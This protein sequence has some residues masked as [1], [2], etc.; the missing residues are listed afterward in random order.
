MRRA[1]RLARLGAGRVH[2]NP[3]VGAVLVKNGRIVGEGAH[4]EFGGPHAEV[5]AARRAG[6]KTEGATLY[7]TLEPC[8]HFGKTPPCADLL[9]SLKIKKVVVGAIDPNPRVS[10][11]GLRRLRA[12]G[13]EVASGVLREEAEVLNQDFACWMKKKRSYGVLKIAQSLDGKIATKTG[14]SQ[15]ITGSES[16][17][18]AQT[19]R[20]ESDAILVGIETVL[21]DNPLLSVRSLRQNVRQPL[22]VILDSGLRISPNARIF[23][24][25]SSGSVCIATTSGAPRSKERLLAKKAKVIR[26]KAKEGRV[27]LEVLFRALAKE[28]I[29][30]ILIE[31]GGEVA[32]DALSSRLV[33]EVYWFVAPKII[34]GRAAVNSVGGV[35][36]SSLE[37]ALPVK[38]LE[39]R[40]LGGDFLIHGVL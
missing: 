6:K 2:P 21:K 1:L 4:L 36:I 7:V 28:G 24:K 38:V 34:G 32:A 14:E 23:S 22:K 10:G 12:A 17:G 20:A 5:N 9:I 33:D 27:D 31:G 3:L 11:K 35:G 40:V 25:A 13:V 19:L 26:I 37:K 18:F 30:R 15:W 16:R 8:A 39:T 29:V